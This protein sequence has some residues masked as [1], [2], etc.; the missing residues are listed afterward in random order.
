MTTYYVVDFGDLAVA[1]DFVNAIADLGHRSTGV[2]SRVR[3]TEGTV[4]SLRQQSRGANV[5]IRD[6]TTRDPINDGESSMPYVRM[7]DYAYPVWPESA[8]PKIA[9]RLAFTRQGHLG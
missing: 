5:T 3:I 6:I 1:H 4:A 2:G 7:G 9:T 8:G